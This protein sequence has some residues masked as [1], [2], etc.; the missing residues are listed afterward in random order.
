MFGFGPRA[1]RILATT[2]MVSVFAAGLPQ[3]AFAA[4]ADG[5]ALLG[6]I[7][8]WLGGDDDEQE[9]AKPP[10]LSDEGVPSN[11]HLP[12][13]KA[14]AKPKR[15]KELKNRRTP[16]ARY[17]QLSD[18]RVQS[19]VSSVPTHYE[20][21][22]D[23]KPIDTAVRGTERD[24]YRYANTTNLARTYFG[25]QP[26]ELVRFE[27]DKGHW[28]VLGIK[29]AE[30]K[31]L[32]PK[33]DGDTVTYENAL[34]DGAD[35]TYT[36]GHGT[37]KEGIVLDGPPKGAP[38]YEF[39]LTTKGLNA[40]RLKGGAIALY[41]DA[42]GPNRP[43]LVIPAPFMTDAKKKADS[44][45]GTAGT[46][47]VSQTLKSS[48]RDGSYEL[49]LRP[50]AKWLASDK[51][52]YPVVIDP[53]ISISPT[54]T[55]S[56]DVMISSDGPTENYDGVWRLSVGNTST[57]S[58][59]ALLKF[60]LGSVPAGTKV[61]SADL[62]L[63]YDQTHTAGDTEVLLEA[64][65][66]TQAWDETTATWNS[67]NGITGELSGTSVLVDD[68]DSGTT[69]AKGAW[70]A[71]TNT[72]Y[73]QYAVNQ[74]YLY[75]KDAVAGDTYTWQPN[76]PEDGDYRVD[77]HY[78]PASD[79]AANAPYTVTYNGGTKAYTVNQTSG[80]GGQWKTLGTHP[81]KAGTAG[82]VVLGDGPASTSTAVLA[83][84]VRLTKGG[85]AVKEP[86]KSNTWNS[87][88]VTKTVQ[89]WING[90][91]P[92]HGFVVKAADESST[93][94]KG[95]PRYEA[96]E[97]AYK[98]EVAN[99]P[100]LVLT[101]G[102]P[103]VA[104]DAPSVI[105]ATGA[106]LDWS[107]YNDPSAD[108]GD[109]IV[110]YQVHR[111]VY[112]TF[113]PS[114][115]TLVAPVDKEKTSFTDTTATP[116]P[117]DSAD[118]FGNVFYYMVA[119]K[120]RDGQVIPAATQIV[121]LPKAG[122]TT[123][124]LQSGQTDTTLSSAQPTTGHDT[125]SDSGL[126]K[127]WLSVG[128]NSST[129]GKTRALLKFP[130]V[131][132][133]PANSRVLEGRLDLWG[134]TT[135]TGTAGAIYEAHGLTRDFDE[136][137]ASWNNAASGT[138]WT[139]AGGDMDAAVADTVGTVTNDPARQSWYLSSL[140]QSWVSDP[141]SN[142]GVAIRLKDESATGPQE[143]TI[144][145]SSEAE[146]PQLR[147]QLVVTYIDKS[148]DSTYFAPYTPARMI[149]GDEYSVDVT[150]TNTTTSV[151]K[152]ADQV[153]SYTWSLPDGTDATTGG[154]QLETALPE[155]VSPGETVTLK[156]ALKAPINSDSGNKRL[157]YVL[158]WDLRNKTAGTWLSAT[159]N[160]PP[161]AQ[162]VRTEDPTSDQ[163]GLEKFYSYAGKNT[164]AGSTLM[165]NLYAGNT[166][167]QYNAF[168]NPGRGLS[169][170]V[171]FAYNSQ[172]TSDTVLG[173]GWS[174]QAA[175]PLR[176]GAALD[177]HPNPNPT[178][179]TLP[180][181]DGTAHVFRKQ[182][183]GTWKAP[184]G[185]HYLLQQGSGVD[186]TPDKDGDPKAWSLTRPDRSQFF[187]DCDG[188]LTSIVDK[189]GNT[190]TYTYEERKS[191]NKPVKFL[192]Y[193]TDP[194]GR[195]SLT[196]DY[197]AKGDSYPYINDA[198]TKVT[199]TNLT[200]P[201]IIDHVK[202]MTDISGRKLEF[203]YSDKGLLG[204]LTDGAGSSQPKV[205]K[206]VYDATQ[207]NKNA[208]LVKVTDPRG[209]STSL[210]YYYPSEGDD[211]KFHWNTQ[212]ITDRLGGDT[213][214][215]YRDTDGTAGSFI[216]TKV[217]D[218]ENH[219]ATHL[220]DGYGR[221]TQITNAKSETTK[222]GWD[223]DN[224]VVR[225]EEAN[226]AVSTWV[227]D[228]K[229]GYLLE[230]KGAEANKNGT[231]AGKL[232]YATGL[233]GYIAD[234]FQKKS[235]EGRTWQFGYDTRG[236]LTSVT[237]PKGVASA[238]ADDY[239]TFYEYN[240]YG[241]LT[242]ATDAN[243]NPTTN[244]GFGPTGYPATITDALGADSSFTYDERGNVTK[245]VNDKGAEVTQTYDVYGRP[246]TKKEP[247]DQAAGL[248]ITT[249]APVY[250]A[251]DNIVQVS[252]PNGTV[253]TSVYDKADQVTETVLPKDEPTDPVRKT[254]TTYDK[255]GNVLTT[256]EPKGNLTPEAG[257]FTTTVRYDAVYQPI[258]TVNASGDKVTTTYD[259]VGNVTKVVDARKNATADPDDYAVK[260]TYDL[261]HRV[262]TSMDAA[263]NTTSSKF[264]LDGLSVSMTDPEGNE[265]LAKYDERGALVE[266]KV[267][268]DKDGSGNPVYRTVRYEYDEVGNPT[269][270]VT[271]RGVATTDDPDDF[272]SETRY[273]ALNRVKEEISPYDK[274]D[275]KYGTP[276]RT[277]YFYDSVGKLSEVSAPPSDG[278]TTRN[279]TKYS[280]YDNGWT[281]TSE[282]PWDIVA[283]YDYND[284]G[285]QTKNTLT[286][287]GGSQSR[288][289]TTDYY[290]S[291]NKKSRSEDGIPVGLAAVVVDSSDFNNTA[292]QGNWTRSQ[293][294]KQYG[295]DT[296]SHPAGTGAD[297]F[298]W[299]LNIP[300]NGTYEVFVR[301]PNMT[302]AATDAKFT[303]DHDGGSVTK[304]VDQ[305]KSTGTWVS[306]GSYAFVEDGPQKVT[307]TD[308]ANG[309][310]L[311]DAVK[312]VR[313]NTG[314][315][316]NEK[317]E[318]TYRYDANGNL[319]EVGD[320]SPNP[321]TDT[322]RLAYDGLNRIAKV[323]EV[324]AGSVK[325]TTALTYDENG[326]PLTSTHDLTWSKF[327]YDI[328]DQV[329]KVTNADSP[330]AGNQQISSFSYTAR[331][332]LLKQTK[333]NG[334][335]V[336]FTYYPDGS[337]KK[338]VEKKAGG[339]TVAQHDLE[340]TLN[341]HR[342]KDVLKLMNADNTSDYIDNTYTY[343]YDPQ[344][345]VTKVAKTG[346]S[347]STETYS[348][349]GNGNVVEQ[350]VGDVPT[351]HR[352]DR[353]R[354]L[355]SASGGVTNTYNYDPL[356]RL[357]TVSAG[358]QTIEK[359]YYDGFDRTAKH[360]AGFG[361][362]ARTTTYTY[363]PFDRTVTQQT[364][365]TEGKTT[366]FTY[367]GIDSTV[368]RETVDGKAD[369]SYQYA[370]WN[371]QLTQIKHKDDGTKELSQYTYH[372]RGDVEAITKEDG[373][374]RATYGYTAYGSDDKQ[375]FS[376]ADKPDEGNPDKET[377]NAFRF[378]AARWDK[379][380]GTY[381]MGFRNYDP[382]LNRFLTRD[383]YGGALGDMALA[384]DP[385]TGNRY[386]FAGGN[387]ITFVE[388]DGHLFGMSWSD[389][390]HAALDVVGLV[391][392][393]GEVA[394]VANGL[395][396]LAEGNYVD[397]ALSMTSAIPLAGYGA[398]AIKAG[399]YVDKGIDAL[400]A[401]NDVRKA[402]DKVDGAV[403]AATPPRPKDT[404]PDGTA[405][406]DQPDAPSCKVN[407]FVPGTQVVMADGS[408]KAIDALDVGDQVKAT[409]VEG[410]DTRTRVVTDTRSHE[411]DKKLVTLTVKSEGKTGKITSTEG[412][413]FW[414][415]DAGR[416][417]DAGDLEPGMW[418]R[419]SAG[420]WVQI[421]AVEHSSR[422]ARVH[423]LT[424]SGV[425]DYYVLAGGI[426]LLVHN[427]C[428]PGGQDRAPAGHQYQ[429][430]VYKNLKDPATGN[431]VPGT[432]INHIPPDSVTDFA[433]GDGPA[434]QMDYLDHRAVY[435][436]GRY[437]ASQA[438]RMWQKEL[439]D[440][441]R[442]DEAVQ[443]D[444][445][446]I[447]R[448]FGTKYDDAI[449]QMVDGMANNPA[450]QA[451]RTVPSQ[452]G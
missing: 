441:G 215:V 260:Y 245:I 428:G 170:F 248:F 46:D 27:L 429:G 10:E 57:G 293:A 45:Y 159:E 180:D 402:E 356:G 406:K 195:Q 450:Y 270:T 418:L 298:V 278:Q 323:E 97:Y 69:A 253:S 451:L 341:G 85:V 17:W 7:K 233:N 51:R 414:L 14:R 247:K 121:K 419:T 147:P 367:L 86:N 151:W 199:G 28:V 408:T 282:D 169:T 134:F 141:A 237:D 207:G 329:V 181:G 38:S 4:P 108:L 35:L 94:P 347:S 296:Y 289:I 68:R 301:Y 392:V 256:T 359:Y 216:E 444:I 32:S 210:D 339:T 182:D 388:L 304:T 74:D 240:T 18:G 431:N 67:A 377:Y 168:S 300:Q 131:S 412:H 88:S 87:F 393:V 157:D 390:G 314:D 398:T 303:V 369:K 269:R 213:G 140:A 354:L 60:P 115:Q 40:K 47:A 394:D 34:G 360:R 239:T 172:D 448:R 173:H 346:D 148:T 92:N 316:D 124:V 205:F 435:S 266:S 318:F 334:N 379:S 55:Q 19:E 219:T 122:R 132:A 244:S 1:R 421:T 320:H 123:L 368:L 56:Q 160:I 155:D 327:E 309:T 221:P 214:Y 236:N 186:C 184:A 401:A 384:M 167:W 361:A 107:S 178:E 223:A 411:G 345:R 417:V 434:I 229:T 62:R 118:S 265:S 212:T 353:N 328:R 200:S 130:G 54:V 176:L 376:G 285:Q 342:A 386:S 243:G 174:A 445:D 310:V 337:I 127:N 204:E 71:S 400:D 50:D 440:A 371:Q 136:T 374:T 380:S 307:L 91:N 252:Q 317:K 61:D 277:F 72:A 106:E 423:N 191:N 231:A 324:A 43:D 13:G 370:P 397:A 126:N 149:P 211:P 59:R 158:K 153:L 119:V 162:N 261:N 319:I 375:Q 313:N 234:I 355:S 335:T 41:T 82:K 144:F 364:D 228:Q 225:L 226:G 399:R 274:D 206:F 152:A 358:G 12:Q 437:R 436:T 11:E 201:K 452:I 197:Y 208:K 350:S 44:P 9:P 373:N 133:I 209:N 26:G 433:Y 332:Q 351:T 254:T 381:D 16:S 128:N 129:Y 264:D 344:D 230:T 154:N 322:Y 227:Y 192:R 125:I 112:Q 70:P 407:S 48:G 305:T 218:A 2:G 348:Y 89:S 95:G 224:N 446:D 49:T 36:V 321:K 422:H 25:E 193:I 196:V 75:N 150:L 283:S 315:T 326:N 198:G 83:D 331:G 15:V 389:I 101:Y 202:S 238:T 425:H 58:S 246:L 325:N 3:P 439:I 78:V 410:D 187:F 65:R 64:H 279:I 273:D 336:D 110:E 24:G 257:D 220:I 294:E 287:A 378:N 259:N 163:L 272:V 77:V 250:D 391:P 372:P 188:Y 113:T 449:R 80:T 114:A 442:I 171:R 37:V 103:G 185:V 165:T 117:A 268:R 203:V 385:F 427:G 424:V 177:F 432:E 297:K 420:T 415:P 79:R 222:L 330:T 100:R 343:E 30:S 21:G 333:P 262:V 93:A 22:K 382:G 255:V 443:M 23:W 145:L 308:A 275:P 276:D 53:T 104:L 286:S 66:A 258:E 6:G 416:W 146:E 166:V 426:E 175:M 311:A 284:L 179:V 291:G 98:G 366:A 387:P 340:Y 20:A 288:T 357:D 281:R 52:S 263:G 241:Q 280:Y 39:T 217:T 96:A 116:T 63:Y 363:D 267:V 73:T 413:E 302:G 183:D 42:S 352:Y 81:F 409:D 76:L 292:I 396:Y 295:Y 138:A 306:L 102:R 290:T 190:Q 90:T 164:G 194:A 299:Q 271:A 33:T 105:H 251:N 312:L 120:T 232:V 235:P 8:D 349:D 404:T 156:A 142:K 395:W 5:R 143:R 31:K 84:A 189:N 403:D 111:S 405:P 139:T 383:M 430:G 29:G 109:D 249:P 362:A 447:R 161:L 242:K 99:Y 137:A 365:G 438:W 338:Q 135:T